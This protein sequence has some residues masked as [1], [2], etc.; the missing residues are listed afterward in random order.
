VG[1]DWLAG[2]QYVLQTRSL[3]VRDRAAAAEGD[4]TGTTTREAP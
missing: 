1:L 4:E 2:A 3:V